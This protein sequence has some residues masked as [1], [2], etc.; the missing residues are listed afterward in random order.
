MSCPSEKN[1]MVTGATGALSFF[2]AWFG[3]T[4]WKTQSNWPISV[5]SVERLYNWSPTL[6]LV[7][8]PLRKLWCL[9]LGRARADQDLTVFDGTCDAKI[10]FPCAVSIFPGSQSFAMQLRPTHNFK[11]NSQI[12]IN[13][14]RKFSAHIKSPGVSAGAAASDDVPR[15]LSQSNRQ[16]ADCDPSSMCH[17][18]EKTL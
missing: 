12:F 6:L 9:H 8:G 11:L 13:D 3:P 1:P 7:A 2:E 10:F 15:E 16:F 14:H 18:P 5:S 17:V 4:W